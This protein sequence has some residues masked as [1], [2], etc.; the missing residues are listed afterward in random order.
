MFLYILHVAFGLSC[1]FDLGVGAPVH[2]VGETP[3]LEYTRDNGWYN[4]MSG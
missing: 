4:K 1:L 2:G 3:D